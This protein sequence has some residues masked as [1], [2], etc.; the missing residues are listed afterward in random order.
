MPYIPSSVVQEV[1]RMDLITYL[2]IYEPC[3]LV[4]FFGNT[5]ITRTHDSLK[6][7][8]RKWMWW[9]Q[10]TNGGSVPDYLIKE[11]GYSFFET[12]ELLAE[13]VNI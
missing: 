1:K 6:L 4:H 2:K 11:K 5:H 9:S 8:N 12:V 7:S 13:Q 10:R 3:K